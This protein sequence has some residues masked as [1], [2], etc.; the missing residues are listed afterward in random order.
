[1]IVRELKLRNFISHRDTELKFTEGLT[2]IVGEN[3]SGK[4]SILDAISY[5]LYKEHSRGKDENVINRRADSALVYLR[6]SVGG[7]DYSV[8]WRIR[9][10]GRSTATLRDHTTGKTILV[11]A[12]EKTA[13]PELEKL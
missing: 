8:E 1:M 11:D 6:F 3:G 2:V 4:T 10:R 13:L 7:R 12:G 9:R 5:V